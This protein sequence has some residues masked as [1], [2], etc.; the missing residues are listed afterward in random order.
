VRLGVWVYGCLRV[1]QVEQKE[2]G[3]TGGTPQCLV[4]V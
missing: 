2:G 4:L 3:D 1:V